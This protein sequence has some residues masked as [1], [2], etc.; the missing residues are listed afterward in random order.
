MQNLKNYKLL[1]EDTITYLETLEDGFIEIKNSFFKIRTEKKDNLLENLIK[2]P[3][4]KEDIKVASQSEDKPIASLPKIDLTLPKKEEKF[5]TVKTIQK[6]IFNPVI[7]SVEKKKEVVQTTPSNILENKKIKLEE[8]PNIIEDNFND[9]KNIITKF[10]TNITTTEEILDDKLAKQK[11]QKYK[12]KNIAANLT[13]LAYKESEKQYKFLE[14]ISIA[15]N[16]YFYSS[17]L[18]SAYVIEK[19]NNWDVFLSENEIFLIIASD[20]LVFELPNL[21]KHYK[22]NPST[23][24]KYLDNIPLFLLPDTSIYLK[25]PS[26]K[27]SLFKTLQQKIINLKK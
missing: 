16:N 26:L 21:R 6:E 9:I 3:L 10:S 15:L 7:T 4:Q 25:E 22:E 5:E 17:K 27:A 18:I 14:K 12:L 8:K 20:H 24:E 23:K 19:E 1:I 13:I 11:S 2:K